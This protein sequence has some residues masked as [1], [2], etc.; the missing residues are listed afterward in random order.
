MKKVLILVS[1]VFMVFLASGCA[2][3]DGVKK[4]SSDAWKSTKGA[5]HEATAE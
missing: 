3:W 4:D 1:A 2:T 5:I